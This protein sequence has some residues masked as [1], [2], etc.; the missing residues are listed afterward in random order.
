MNRDSLRIAA[1]GI[2]VTIA[3]FVLA[4]QFVEPSPPNTITI[5]SGSKSGAYFQYA[6][7]YAEILARNNIR[8]EVINTQGSLDNIGLLSDG[9]VDVAF[10]QGGVGD[11]N[12]QPDLMSLGSLYFEPLWVFVSDRSKIQHLSDLSGR[13]IAAGAEGSGTWAVVRR[14]MDENG[15]DPES[16]TIQHL[17]S[18]EG[19]IGPVEAACAEPACSTSRSRV[20]GGRIRLRSMA[21][22]RQRIGQVV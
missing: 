1:L 13:K 5:A 19:V 18:A 4:Y 9:K 3:G 10:V 12:A 20:R 17:S 7:R 8:L 2:V 6:K 21:F 15:I 16:A 22:L 11:A 14:L